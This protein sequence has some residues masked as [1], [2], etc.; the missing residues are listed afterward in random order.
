M[1]RTVNLWRS[2]VF[3]LSLVILTGCG[4]P[5]ADTPNPGA[6][7]DTGQ[8]SGNPP[9]TAADPGDTADEPLIP[10]SKDVNTLGL[11]NPLVIVFNGDGAPAI[12]GGAGAAVS[13]DTNH[14]A[15]T[16]TQA[17]ADIVAQGICEDGSL[18]FSGN[19]PFNLYL[20]GLGLVSAS[21]AAISNDG[22]GA[23]NVTL[24]DG[25]ANRL[26]DGAGGAQKA[27]FYSKGDFSI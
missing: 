1:K 11:A 16:L 10:N 12:T 17:G 2:G 5:A 15:V 21:G 25:T 19:Y 20:N 13:A 26:V 23:M 22:S 24:V 9:A 18:T 4:N 3:L 6:A 14:A 8:E 7:D 27:A